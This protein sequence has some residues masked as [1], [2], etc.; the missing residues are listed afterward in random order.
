LS[1]SRWS[2]RRS[3]GARRGATAAWR[4]PDGC[5]RS[6]TPSG[7]TIPCRRRSRRAAALSNSIG[8]NFDRRQ[9]FAD[10]RAFADDA[11]DLGRRA[12]ARVDQSPVERLFQASHLVK[13]ALALGRQQAATVTDPSQK[14]KK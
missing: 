8:D 4:R 5:G 6:S 7:R 12:T 1:H 14:T 9:N 10:R 2:S 11:V 3:T 13:E